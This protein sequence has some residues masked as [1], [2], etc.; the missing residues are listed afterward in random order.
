MVKLRLRRVG[1][2]KQASYRVVAADVRSPRNGAFIE[3]LGHYNPR[4]EPPII[5]IN[6]ERA[7]HWLQH[8]AQP[9]STVASLLKK[10]GIVNGEAPAAAAPS[11]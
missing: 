4:T 11:A 9:T 8:G 5:V 2:K 10:A 6:A 7:R 1:A 3:A